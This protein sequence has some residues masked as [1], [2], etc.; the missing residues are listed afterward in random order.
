MTAREIPTMPDNSP[1]IQ[2]VSAYRTIYLL[3]DL[4]EKTKRLR[5]THYACVLSHGSQPIWGIFSVV[6]GKLMRFLGSRKQV[7][8]AY[9]KKAWRIR[10]ATWTVSD[11]SK[12]ELDS[13]ERTNLVKAQLKSKPDL[14]VVPNDGDPVQ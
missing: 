3:C 9:P 4:N 5:A 10:A 1:T 6:T 8:H 11:V 12:H 14:K 7:E 2:Q 13:T